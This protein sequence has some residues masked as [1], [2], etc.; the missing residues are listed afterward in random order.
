MIV[1]IFIVMIS[2]FINQVFINRLLLMIIFILVIGFLKLLRVILVRIL[3]IVHSRLV[4]LSLLLS[5]VNSTSIVIMIHAPSLHVGMLLITNISIAR[6][7][8][9]E[10][11]ILLLWGMMELR[12]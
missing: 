4:F 3:V 12:L 2:N 5:I 10:V 6:F 11:E 9:R 8:I 1:V 7:L